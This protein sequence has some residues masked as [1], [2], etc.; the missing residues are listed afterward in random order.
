MLHCLTTMVGIMNLYILFGVVN[1]IIQVTSFLGQKKRVALETE[2]QLTIFAFMV[3]KK[4][5]LKHRYF[6]ERTA[7]VWYL[8]ISYFSS[9][10]INFTIVFHTCMHY[11][12]ILR[13]LAP[14][15]SCALYKRQTCCF[16]LQAGVE[17]VFQITALHIHFLCFAGWIGQALNRGLHTKNRHR[18]AT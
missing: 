12:L 1:S 4:A 15:Y 17:L 2:K 7:F 5:L 13:Y 8:F 3:I 16:I 11:F 14:K 10:S 9:F 18:Q 6:S